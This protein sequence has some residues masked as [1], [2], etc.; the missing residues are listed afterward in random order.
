[1][2]KLNNYSR[3]T[4]MAKIKPTEK[5]VWEAFGKVCRKLE[6]NCS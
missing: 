6:E 4:N 2:H 1:M 3:N 5:R